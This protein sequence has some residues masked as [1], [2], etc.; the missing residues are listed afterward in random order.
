VSLQRLITE[1]LLLGLDALVEVHTTVELRQALKAGAMLVGI[2]N[3]DLRT[4]EVR[5]ET[6]LELLPQVPVPVTTV[7]ESGLSTPE[8]LRALRATRC[9]AVLMGEAFMTSDDPAG[10]LARLAAAARG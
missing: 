5:L 4:F 7:A 6:A 8:H 3:R 9:D 10:T 2:N 1:A